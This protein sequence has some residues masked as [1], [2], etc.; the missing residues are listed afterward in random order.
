[1]EIRKTILQGGKYQIEKIIGQNIFNKV[2]LGN[3]CK[4]NEKI[5][6]KEF[7]YEYSSNKPLT[8]KLKRDFIRTGNLLRRLDHRYIVKCLDVFEENCTV[9]YVTEF[10]SGVCLRDYLEQST[11]FDITLRIS[12]QRSI[13][14]IKLIA[15]A[16]DYL[17]KRGICHLD[18]KPSNIIYHH[19]HNEGY[20]AIEETD[21]IKLLDFANAISFK[22]SL[23]NED[24]ESSTEP[25][26]AGTPGYAPLELGCH[27]MKVSPATD[28]YSLGATWYFLLTGQRPPSATDLLE[29]GGIEDIPGASEKVN[30]AISAAMNPVMKRRPQSI[31][32]FLALYGEEL[33]EPSS[34]DQIPEF[35]VEIETENNSQQVLA[36]GT[37]L[38][39]PSYTYVIQQILGQGGFGITYLASVKLK[40]LLGTLNSDIKVAV[41]EFF[42]KDYCSREDNGT[43]TFSDNS[44]GSMS[45]K[46]AKKFVKEAIHLSKLNHPNIVKVVESFE[47]NNTSYYVMEYLEGK[48][49]DDHVMDNLGLSEYEAITFIRQIGSALSYMHSHE[50]LHMDV[51]PKNVMLK[52]NQCILID[53]GLAKQYDEQ[54]Q[55]ES[56]T[57]LGAGT[58]GYAP[59]EQINYN[60]EKG[61]AP[62]IDVYALGATLYKLLTAKTPPPAS[63]ILNDGF[64]KTE[65]ENINVSNETIDV[66]SM[67]MEPRKKDRIQSIEEFLIMLPNEGYLSNCFKNK[68]QQKSEDTFVDDKLSPAHHSNMEVINGIPVSW[69]IK[70]TDYQ[71][72]AI[73]QLLKKLEKL[74]DG[75]YVSRNDFISEEEFS[76]ISSKATMTTPMA[77]TTYRTKNQIFEFIEIIISLTQNSGFTLMDINHFYNDAYTFW[78]E[79]EDIL[80]PKKEMS[81]SDLTEASYKSEILMKVCGRKWSCS[82]FDDTKDQFDRFRFKIMIDSNSFNLK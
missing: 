26:N 21:S 29:N 34:Q 71:K 70:A 24:I 38:T 51:K 47:H 61:F 2:Y 76:I 59:L 43:V 35:E 75:R 50:L 25:R 12:E 27:N 20:D 68:K 44:K 32:E 52:D 9:Y 79:T 55:P 7:S 46:Y 28:I 15:E 82:P 66:I 36:V 33:A 40:G 39:G 5:I 22:D 37:E 80:M 10:S 14:I 11:R 49:L 60:G 53:F 19:V 77:K 31:T 62:T 42:M 58:P 48:S 8:D 41:K 74:Y 30:R 13:S 3:I 17:H 67:A 1:M 18:V 4:S 65:L 73:R 57:G 16:L 63:V 81:F 78:D 45:L 54:G 23:I 64:D 6:I 56:S 69:N 72:N